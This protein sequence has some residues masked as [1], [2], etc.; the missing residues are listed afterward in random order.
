LA[1]KKLGVEIVPVWNKSNREHNIIGS[2]PTSTRAAADAAVKA[3]GW[4]APYFLDAELLGREAGGELGLG[5]VG[6]AVAHAEGEFTDDERGCA[7][8]EGPQTRGRRAGKAIA[9][10]LDFSAFH[11]IRLSLPRRRWLIFTPRPLP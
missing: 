5:L 4:T 11:A 9:A 6:E 8:G 3:L 1:A 7:H 2:E 10:G